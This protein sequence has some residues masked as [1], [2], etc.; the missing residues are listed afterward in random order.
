MIMN[1]PLLTS[2]EMSFSEI[3]LCRVLALHVSFVGNS[4]SNSVLASSA[5]FFSDSSWDESSV[6]SVSTVLSSLSAFF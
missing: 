6:L 3:K 1:S 2:S 5:F 4:V